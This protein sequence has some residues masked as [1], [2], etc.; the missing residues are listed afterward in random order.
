MLQSTLSEFRMNETECPLVLPIIQP[1]LNH[2]KCDSLGC[3]AYITLV[4][5]LPAEN[6]LRILMPPQAMRPKRV[7]EVKLLQL[8]HVE[9]ILQALE[10]MHHDVAERRTSGREAV[11][12][13]Q[14]E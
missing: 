12:R 13:K 7:D 10:E 9:N 5:G 11:N 3:N 1:A 6:L 8:L 4:A 2:K 14:N